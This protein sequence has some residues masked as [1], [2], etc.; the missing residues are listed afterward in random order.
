MAVLTSDQGLMRQLDERTDGVD[1]RFM[2][3]V[4]HFYAANTDQ[5]FENAIVE[6]GKER[7]R[8]CLTKLAPSV[9][10]KAEEQFSEEQIGQFLAAVEE[11]SRYEEVQRF[12]R[13]IAECQ[14][15]WSILTGWGVN[16]YRK[17]LAAGCDA[18][19]VDDRWR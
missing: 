14:R 7:V 16:Q 19:P 17:Q 3:W 13:Q 6:F 5:L 4:G 18:L 11:E 9:L 15:L 1:A 12:C 10:Q 8:E 2:N